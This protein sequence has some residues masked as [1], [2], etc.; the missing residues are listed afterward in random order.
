MSDLSSAQKLRDKSIQ[1]KIELFPKIWYVNTLTNHLQITKNF[2]IKKK[3][4]TNKLTNT[5]TFILLLVV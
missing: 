5:L 3:T 2:K 1:H 4:L